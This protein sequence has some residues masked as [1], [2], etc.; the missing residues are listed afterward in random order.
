MCWIEFNLN[1]DIDL[2]FLNN[3]YKINI[4]NHKPHMWSCQVNDLINHYAQHSRM[5]YFF[6]Y[7]VAYQPSSYTELMPRQ[8][9]M[10]KIT[11]RILLKI[12]S[13]QL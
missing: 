5:V 11:L 8:R 7:I 13:L 10:L 12:V 1:Y 3:L 9:L 4:G 2:T 6:I